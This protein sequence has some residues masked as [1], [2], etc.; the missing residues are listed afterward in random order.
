MVRERRLRRPLERAFARA[1][2]GRR[3]DG[4]RRRA[5]YLLFDLDDGSVWLVHLGMSSTLSVRPA[6][7]PSGI[8]THVI[9]T[10]D[11]GTET[12]PFP[13]PE[14]GKIAQAI[15]IEASVSKSLVT[16]DLVGRRSGLQSPRVAPRLR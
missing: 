6:E 5:K 14:T 2:L 9:A 11:D 13:R 12:F 15:P 1:L 8:H 4:V 16:T 10:L 3:I 7:L